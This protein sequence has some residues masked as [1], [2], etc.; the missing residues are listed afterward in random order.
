MTDSCNPTD[1]SPLDSSVPGISQTR[2]LEW[3]VISFSRGSSQPR[4]QIWVFCIAGRFFTG[5]A[6]LHCYKVKS[7]TGNV[8]FYYRWFLLHLTCHTQ[9][10]LSWIAYIGSMTW[11]RKHKTLLWIKSEI[12]FDS[13]TYQASLGNVFTLCSVI[14]IPKICCVIVWNR[15]H[16]T[17]SEY[18]FSHQ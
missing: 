2:I 14:L 1:C 9:F 13:D 7:T 10:N 4:D 16:L 18:Q 11:W 15:Y 12:N 17:L 8:A 5:W 6:S 3:V